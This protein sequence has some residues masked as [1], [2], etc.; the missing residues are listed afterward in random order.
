[1]IGH[2]ALSRLG[3]PVVFLFLKAGT[4]LHY[5]IVHFL[6]N[7]VA[8]SWTAIE[9]HGNGSQFIRDAAR[10]ISE[11]RFLLAEEQLYPSM[12]RLNLVEDLS[13]ARASAVVSRVHPGS[14]NPLI[15][16]EIFEVDVQL[17]T[18]ARAFMLGVYGSRSALL[19]L[20]VG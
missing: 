8:L 16:S 18:S 17:T 2:A 19:R 9:Q 12:I 14:D 5:E 4:G 15:P 3:Y 1:M 6:E 10:R 13:I 20:R 7:V 11:I